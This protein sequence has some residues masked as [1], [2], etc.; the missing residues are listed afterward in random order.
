MTQS[1][2]GFQMKIVIIVSYLKDETSSG[3]KRK[4]RHHVD[5]TDR[6]DI[7]CKSIYKRTSVTFPKSCNSKNV[8]K[9]TNNETKAPVIRGL[10]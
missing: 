10:I 3:Y 5:I 4:K 2:A 9:K 1:V 8:T 7:M 6:R